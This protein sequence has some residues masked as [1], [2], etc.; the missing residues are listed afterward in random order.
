MKH[1]ATTAL[2]ALALAFLITAA[3]A[4]DFVK[5]G[6]SPVAARFHD[7][8]GREVKLDEVSGAP[9]LLHFWASWCAS[10][11]EEFPAL[12]RLQRDLGKDGLKVVTVSID[13][14]GWPVIDKT[15]EKLQ[16]RDALVF[17]DRNREAAMALK[18]EVL[19]TTLLLDAGGREVARLKG[20]GEWDDAALRGQI[21]TLT[22]R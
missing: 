19:P 14:M 9:T 2:A 13:R 6:P 21:G 12:D 17:H 5:T 8:E 1:P 7:R 20:S 16:V 15:I 3:P 11:R 4:A 22:A 18:I 10:C